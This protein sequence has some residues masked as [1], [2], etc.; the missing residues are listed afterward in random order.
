MACSSSGL[1]KTEIGI[2]YLSSTLNG[3]NNFQREKFSVGLMSREN[4][5]YIN[6]YTVCTF[7]VQHEMQTVIMIQKDE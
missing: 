6:I 2:F 7:A 3:L 5:V 4:I 1:W